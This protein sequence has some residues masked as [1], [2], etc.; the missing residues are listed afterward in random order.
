MIDP[1]GLQTRALVARDSWST[2]PD[3]GPG[4]ESY[5]TAGRPR[6]PLDNGKSCPGLP[7]DPAG[8]WSY[9][10][11]TRESWSTPQAFRTRPELPG[12]TGGPRLLSGMGLSPHDSWSNPQGLGLGPESQGTPGRPRG[13]LDNG[14]SHPALLGDPAGT[15]SSS[16]VTRESWSTPRPSD[17][18]AIRLGYLVDL[19]GPRARA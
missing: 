17:L 15:W 16:R 9:A 10:R 19:A 6:R 14:L 1:E 8:T 7:V 11:V 4:P 2:Q 5:R 18:G 12:T 13:P 3:L